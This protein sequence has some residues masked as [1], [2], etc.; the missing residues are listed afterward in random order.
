MK[1][2]VVSLAGLV[3]LAAGIVRAE[4]FD[5]RRARWGM[6]PGEVRNS[7]TEAVPFADMEGILS[8]QGTIGGVEAVIFYLFQDNHLKRGVYSIE[9]VDPSEVIGDYQAAR[10]LLFELHGRPPVEKLNL[11]DLEA[12]ENLDPTDLEELLRLV[13]AKAAAPMTYWETESTEIYLRLDEKDGRG[14][15]QID[16]ISRDR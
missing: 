8:Y 14:T 9:P 2:I 6:S 11:E 13:L 15:I 12:A 16:Y 1:T 10:S 5:F 7:E 4:E 3:L